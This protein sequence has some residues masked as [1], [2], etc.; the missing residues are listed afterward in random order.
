MLPCWPVSLGSGLQDP[1][2]LRKC[3][4][5]KGEGW[6]SSFLSR[7]SIAALPLPGTALGR[8]V[9]CGGGSA[10]PRMKQPVLGLGELQLL[11]AGVAQKARV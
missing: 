7:G 4:P 11:P 10:Y 1:Q 2:S 8:H 5:P 3:L 9:K 6:E